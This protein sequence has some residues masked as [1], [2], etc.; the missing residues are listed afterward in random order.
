L[1]KARFFK[2]HPQQ[3]DPASNEKLQIAQQNVSLTQQRGEKRKKKTETTNDHL[4]GI[5]SRGEKWGNTDEERRDKLQNKK[6]SPRST[7]TPMNS[8][9]IYEGRSLFRIA[10]FLCVLTKR[11][12]AFLPEQ[13]MRGS[14]Q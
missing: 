2:R 6:K 12:S 11:R 8:H 1:V 5:D 13:A 7:V 10:C 9:F 4:V 14:P 3:I